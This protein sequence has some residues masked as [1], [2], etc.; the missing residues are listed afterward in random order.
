MLPLRS[1]ASTTSLL[2]LCEWTADSVTIRS[3]TF[4]LSSALTISSPHIVAP[5]MPPTSIHSG[6]PAARSLPVS[7]R[8]RSLS[9]RL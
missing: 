9:S 5:S 8:T 7:S 4:A 6:T 3:R 2:T 1:L